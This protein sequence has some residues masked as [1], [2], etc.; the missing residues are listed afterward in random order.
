MKDYL[1]AA[2]L[3]SKGLLGVKEDLL[4]KMHN[5]IIQSIEQTIIQLNET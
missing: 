4:L 5:N 3:R 2:S 1:L